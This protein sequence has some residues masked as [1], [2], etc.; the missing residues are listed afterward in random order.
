MS[1]DETGTGIFALEEILQS[2]SVA[3]SNNSPN[4]GHHA[5]HPDVVPARAELETDAGEKSSNFKRSDSL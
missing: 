1:I 3:A 5:N 2:N 4:G